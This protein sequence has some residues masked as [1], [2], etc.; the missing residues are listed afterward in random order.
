MGVINDLLTLGTSFDT[1]PPREAT[2]NSIFRN[3]SN[4]MD[5]DY[6]EDYAAVN[7][8]Q[9]IGQH[10]AG[11][12]GGTYS[13]TI[14]GPD[15]TEYETA[16]LDFDATAAEIQA[17]V[18]E[19]VD[20]VYDA[21]DIVI[22]DSGTE[23]LSDGTLTLTFSGPTV[24]GLQFGETIITNIDL[25]DDATP[26]DEGAVTIVAEGSPKR[27]GLA[28]LYAA[29]V[30]GGDLPVFGEAPTDLVALNT[31]AS[32]PGMVNA[33]TIKALARQAVM[34]GEHDDTYATVLRLAGIQ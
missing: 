16:A 24:A 12:D 7:A 1:D 3:L 20:G 15:G 21:G 13:L 6:P 23:G 34:D 29:G 4:V 22:T 8:V 5:I 14:V 31:R 25:V 2:N 18:D 27:M 33:E 9:T 28:G 10:E 17:E 30:I 32:Y 19:A 26:T 11:T